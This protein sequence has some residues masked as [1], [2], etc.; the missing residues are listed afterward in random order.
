MSFIKII[1]NDKKDAESEKELESLHRELEDPTL[2]KESNNDVQVEFD[3]AKKS[4]LKKRGRPKNEEPTQGIFIKLPL[5]L[6][7]EI[8]EKAKKSHVGYQSLIKMILSQHV[9]EDKKNKR[10]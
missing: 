7:A 2:W 9:Q 10:A 1:K 4:L 3:Q 5:S 8:K 6:I